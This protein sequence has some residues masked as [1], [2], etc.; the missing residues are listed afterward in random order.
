MGNAKWIWYRSDFEIYHNMLLHNRRVDMGVEFP[1]KW[2]LCRPEC[3]V[4]FR[5][6]FT[7]EEDFTVKII[8]HG[9]GMV[10]LSGDKFM[11]ARPN[12]EF[13]VPKGKYNIYV[14]IYDLICFP[15]IFCNSKY[16]ITDESWTA[17]RC[18]DIHLPVDCEPAYYSE[19][20]DPTVFPFS[21]CDIAPVSKK[22]LDDG[23][24]L[25]DFGD[26]MFGPVK[27]ISDKADDTVLYSFGESAQEALD[28][29]YS[30]IHDTVQLI[31]GSYDIQS[32][33]FRY[34]KLK[35]LNGANLSI[36]AQLEYL[37][38]DDKASFE[39]DDE[40]V[41]AIWNMCSKTFHLNSREFYLDGIKRDRWVWSGDAYQS[42]MI[43]R[44]LYDEPAI[45]KRTI[46]ALLGRPPILQ[47]INTINDYSAF[48]IISVWEYYFASGD[49]AFVQSIWDYLKELFNF[50]EA[51]LAD[52][53]VVEHEVDWVFI[54]WSDIDK[55]GAVC[56]EQILL[57]H[58]YTIM[59]KLAVLCGEDG[60]ALTEKAAAFR[61][62]IIIDYYDDSRSAFIDS[63]ESGKNHISRHA[64]I[65]AILYDF[66][67]DETARKIAQ[68]VLYNDE[69]T[70]ITTPY[71]KLYELMAIGKLGDVGYLQE[72]IDSYWGGMAA[73]GASTVWE[74]FNP[75]QS[76]TEHYSMYGV[77]YAKSLCHAW[78]SGPI[79]LLCRY[80]LGVYST[81]IGGKTFIVSPSVGKYTKIHAKTPIGGGI[82][83]VDYENGVMRVCS[84]VGGGTLC[85]NGEEIPLEPN[86]TVTL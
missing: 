56:A 30:I 70:Q 81:S 26:E 55:T 83:T 77:K 42:F 84:T 47:H 21:Y 28:D 16:L 67:D 61:E 5:S 72:Y 85:Y 59:A 32:F 69:I 1:T 66:V 46:K 58:V 40:S 50:I 22:S 36:K 20:D 45:I 10:E 38:I 43:N 11:R 18:D 25:Y 68:N 44:C 86:V 78:G 75:N 15:S 13:A 2:H 39:C 76:G 33:A 27:I 19:D 41:N 62:R 80:V 52:G 4:K 49:K 14:E 8:S 7:A 6:S 31:D 12:E 63:F 64:N 23:G 34:I 71:F 9:R 3:A 35:S 57:W 60:S 48:L 53:Y 51:R 82:V 37:P 74:E 73:L 29:K 65:F 54:D 24:V 79:Y 17:D